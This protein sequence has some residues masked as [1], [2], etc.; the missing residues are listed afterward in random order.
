VLDTDAYNID[1]FLL[2]HTCVSSIQL[3]GLFGS[4]RAILHLEKPDLQEVFPSKTNSLLTE[5][6]SARC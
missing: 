6:Q 3:I 2:G 4:N 5:K 1:G